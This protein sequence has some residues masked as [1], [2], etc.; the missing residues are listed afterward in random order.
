MMH[1]F[2]QL[3]GEI[4][5]RDIFLSKFKHV[6]YHKNVDKHFALYCQAIGDIWCHIKIKLLAIAVMSET[7]HNH[8]LNPLPPLLA[9]CFNLLQWTTLFWRLLYVHVHKLAVLFIFST[10][11][12]AWLVC[13]N[14]LW[15]TF[16]N[17]TKSSRK[18]N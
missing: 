5:V 15:C 4:R 1:A 10:K 3:Y 13:S 17:I 7:F 6:V 14:A 18:F 16:H 11:T 2:V 12:Q 9:M 8:F